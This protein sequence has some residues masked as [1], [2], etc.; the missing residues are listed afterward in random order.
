MGGSLSGANNSFAAYRTKYASRDPDLSNMRF[1]DELRLLTPADG[2]EE[3]SFPPCAAAKTGAAPRKE[4]EAEVTKY[5]WVVAPTAVPFALELL[6]DV[7][8]ERGRLSHTNLT[9]GGPAHSGGEMWF[10]DHSIII[11]NGGSGRYP[12][13]SVDELDEVAKAFKSVGYKVA[14]MGWDNETSSPARYLRGDPQWL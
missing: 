9:G 6:P 13:R 8:F 12:P 4:R 14:H 1:A 3:L 11:M 2:Y 5:L 7:R 10:T